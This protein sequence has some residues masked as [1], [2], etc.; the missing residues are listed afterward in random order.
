MLLAERAASERKGGRRRNARVLDW[1]SSFERL[2]R[3]A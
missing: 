2:P 3:E 1:F